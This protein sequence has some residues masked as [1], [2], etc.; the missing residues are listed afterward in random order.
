MIQRFFN[1]FFPWF[2][3]NISSESFRNSF[4]Y[5]FR[6]CTR[7]F[8]NCSR[9]STKISYTNVSKNSLK[10]HQE[11]FAGISRQILALLLPVT[12]QA[13]TPPGIPA[14]VH[15]EI[16]SDFSSNISPCII[17]EMYPAFPPNNFSPRVLQVI[18]YNVFL[19]ISLEIS[20]GLSHKFYLGIFTE[21]YR[22]ISR[23]I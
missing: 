14:R 9:D 17:P 20:L 11:N 1:T 5:F 16:S 23:G 18:H 12:T 22:C 10:I 8:K 3:Q 7:D 19:E 13:D 15:T 2:F 6:K 21:A 4:R